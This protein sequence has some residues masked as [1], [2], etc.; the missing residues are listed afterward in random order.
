MK[1]DNDTQDFMNML[2]NLNIFFFVQSGCLFFAKYFAKGQRNWLT[3]IASVIDKLN[4]A[5]EARKGTWAVFAMFWA[6]VAA[7]MVYWIRFL[8]FAAVGIVDID[9]REDCHL[10]LYIYI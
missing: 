6:V 4:A 9:D 3:S 10:G 5:V 8:K 2:H 1:L 7:R